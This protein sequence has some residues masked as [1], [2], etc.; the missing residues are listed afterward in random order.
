MKWMM[1]DDAGWK[2]WSH[3][4]MI[5]CDM[6]WYGDRDHCYTTKKNWKYVAR[7]GFEPLKFLYSE[8]LYNTQAVFMGIFMGCLG[9][10]GTLKPK[11]EGKHG[12]FTSPK[13]G[14]WAARL[15]IW[16][17]LK[18]LQPRCCL[19]LTWT[20]FHFWGPLLWHMFFR[21]GEPLWP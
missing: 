2:W 4:Y 11:L 13:Y 18:N 1:V 15:G 8:F 6:I 19:I 5:W 10:L 21:S 12:K 20:P 3:S 7:L 17:K 9:K 14:Y 16:T